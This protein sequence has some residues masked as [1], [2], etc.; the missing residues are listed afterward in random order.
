MKQ[1][2]SLHIKSRLRKNNLFRVIIISLSIV[3]IIPTLLII[4]KIFVE[5]I[6]QFSFGFFS[7]TSPDSLQAMVAKA[8]NEPVPGGILNG[9]TG[10]AI[11]VLIAVVIAVPAGL[12]TGIYLSEN[13]TG[14]YSNFVRSISELLQG[15]PSIVLGIISYQ[16]IVKN[17]TM[18]F[19]ALAGGMALSVMMLPMIIR[20]TEETMKMIPGEIKE[21][22][23]SLG[24]PYHTVILKIL[25]PTGMKGLSTGTLISV[26]RVMGET[27]P[28]IMTALGSSFINFNVTQP[29]SAVPLLIWEFYNDPNMISLVWGSSLFLMVIVLALN[30]ASRFTSTADKSLFRK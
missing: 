3:T 9:I 17:V 16:W 13:S 29:T 18:G 11:M 24:A 12:F 20:A 15:V 26:S 27:A 25:I 23:Y 30:L 6:G 22:A 28:L 21:A 4:G 1:D 19:S 14:R 8:N 2:Y 7:E 5:G 10:T